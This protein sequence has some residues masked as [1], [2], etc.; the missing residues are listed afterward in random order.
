VFSKGYYLQ[1]LQTPPFQVKDIAFFPIDHSYLAVGI[2]YFAN[3]ILTTA[4]FNF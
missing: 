3:P 2:A 1:K 4:K